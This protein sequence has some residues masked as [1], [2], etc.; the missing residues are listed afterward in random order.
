MLRSNKSCYW[1]ASSAIRKNNFNCTNE[2][3]FNSVKCSEDKHNLLATN[4]DL[5]AESCSNAEICERNECTHCHVI[6]SSDVMSAIGKL[7]TDKISDNGLVYSNNF[8]HGT[9]LL[10]KYLG[11]LYT[12]MIYH[13]FCP[14]LFICANII[15]IPKSSK[16]NVSDSDKYRSMAISSIL[17]KILDRIIIVKQ[18]DTLT[19][20]QH[21]YSLKA[22]SST[23]LCSTMVIE[24]VQYYT[25]NGARP[26]YVL[27]LDASKAFDK[28]AFN[29]LFNELRDRAVCPRIIKLLY[30]N[31]VV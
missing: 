8:T 7:K 18:S 21:Q 22:N 30:F 12:S 27:L 29:V 6:S 26:M 19:T 13:G 24:T 20:S 16:V 5:E 4:I 3:L 10:Y 1:K 14:A 17:G 9:E 15:P 25:E 2:R 11:I 23:V 28:V 31:H